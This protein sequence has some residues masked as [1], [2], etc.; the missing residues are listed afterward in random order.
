MLR[1]VS[2]LAA[3][4]VLVLPSVATADTGVPGRESD[5]VV[6]DGADVP[7]LLGAQPGRVVAFSWD[8]HW[9]QIPVQVDERAMIDYA[10]VRNGHQTD[11]RPF[12][13]LAYTD[14]NTRAGA[15]PDPS[16][17][18]DDEIAAMAMD[19]GE[20]ADGA[21]DPDGVQSGS[22]VALRITDPTDPGT[23]RFIY[24]FRSDGSLDPAAGRSYVTYDFK[25]LSGDPK[26]T[27]KYSG[28][29]GGDSTTGGPSANPEDSTVSTDFYR[30]HLHDRWI[31]D[32]LNVRAPGAT[33]VDILDG[34]KAQVAYGCGRSEVTFS[35]GGGGFIANISGPVRAIRSY[36]GANSGTYTQRDQIYYQRRE[37]DTTYL[38]VHPGISVISQYLDYSA[39]ANGM[40]YRNSNVPAGVTIDRTP[41]PGVETGT[42]LGQPFTWE[43]V[44]GPQGTLSIINRMETN[45]PGV[46][47]GS[48]Y[49]DTA[50]PE[51][52]QCS[53]YADSEAWGASGAAI[54]NAG[55]NTDPTLAPALGYNYD[56]SATRS[57]YFSE[58][59]GTSDLAAERAQQVDQPL[60]VEPGAGKAKLRLSVP[61]KRVRAKVG[62]TK[63]L[64]VRIAN[65]GD[66][67]TGRVKLCGSGPKKLVRVGGCAK[68]ASVA[69]GKSRTLRVKFKLRPAAARKGSVKVKLFT[70]GPGLKKAKAAVKI[71]PA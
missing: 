12:S 31:G 56:F 57:I 8:G 62:K 10:S 65:N 71:K 55:Q 43:Q 50:T 32:E 13:H 44:T 29:A 38:R 23:A 53:S 26:T 24:L 5:P 33:G 47:M 46:N 27:Y 15:D 3:A 28:V 17:D 16:L 41:D 69:P 21:A 61:G 40:T 48:Y 59:G 1:L 51:A 70:S 4:A 18:G 36:I 7:A 52:D 2:L 39:A 35:R 22:R 60:Q 14:P 6:V 20:Q 9:Q 64:S 37:V 45:M 34:D 19:S 66:V 67:A 25:L 49:E 63:R 42:S 68:A 58:P 30:E 11:G 54:T